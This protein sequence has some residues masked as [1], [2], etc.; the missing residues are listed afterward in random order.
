MPA[1]LLR[2]VPAAPRLGLGSESPAVFFDYLRYL[3]VADGERARAEFGTP[4]Y[5][6]QEAWIAFVASKG[7][8]A[9]AER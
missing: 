1:R 6:T 9:W 2:S 7:A 4:L 5:T 8:Y 3:W